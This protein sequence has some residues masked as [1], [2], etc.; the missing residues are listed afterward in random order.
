M[1][2]PENANTAGVLRSLAEA[3]KPY[4]TGVKA[5]PRD[6]ARA[7]VWR[8]RRLCCYSLLYLRMRKSR[9]KP[10]MTIAPHQVTAFLKRW[11]EGETKLSLEQ[12][13]PLNAIK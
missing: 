10:L 2:V 8:S 5:K 13:L 4:I 12:L 1:P 6:K 9:R 3:E 7:Q 11:G